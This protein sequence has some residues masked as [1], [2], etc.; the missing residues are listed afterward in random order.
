[1]AGARHT[2]DRVQRKKDNSVLRMFILAFL[3]GNLDNTAECLVQQRQR[4][5]QQHDEQHPGVSLGRAFGTRYL[6][7]HRSGFSCRPP[8]QIET[9]L[10]AQVFPCANTDSE[11]WTA[12]SQTR[13]KSQK[14]DH[15]VGED[16]G[17]E[18]QHD[19]EDHSAFICFFFPYQTAAEH[20]AFDIALSF[21]GWICAR[22]EV[23][24]VGLWL[25]V[26]RKW[27]MLCSYISKEMLLRT[28]IQTLDQF[29]LSVCSCL[30]PRS[31]S[32][33]LFP[34]VIS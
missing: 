24:R 23:I 25:L 30:R 17:D 19:G 22:G 29:G 10:L 1:M 28:F 6:D 34:L 2:V 16:T 18:R 14:H 5:A 11:S 15:G 26:L 4:R 9:R 7:G 20:C 3:L 31:F 27:G 12:N 33:W 8:G 21:G 32:A 13:R